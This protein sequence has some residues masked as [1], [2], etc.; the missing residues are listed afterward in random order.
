MKKGVIYNKLTGAI[1]MN[2]TAP[3]EDGVLIQLTGSESWAALLD[4]ELDNGAYYI[5]DEKP[6][7]RPEMNVKIS[8]TQLAIGETM[9]VSNIPKGSTVYHPGGVTQVDDGYIEWSAVEPDSY[10]FLIQN[11]PY[12][13]VRFDAVVG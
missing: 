6:A 10:H 5:V 13:E 8:S 3:D 2:V 7:A 1:V 9:K 11:F 12:K 4:Q